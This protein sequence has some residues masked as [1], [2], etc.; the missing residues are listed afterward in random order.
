MS[1]VADFAYRLFPEKKKEYRPLTP[2]TYPANRHKLHDVKAVIIDVYG[3]LINYWREEF[4]KKEAKEHCLEEAFAKTAQYFQFSEILRQ[5]NP[6]DEP[7]RTLRDF[8]HGLIALNHEKS[9][10]KGIEFPEVRIEEVWEVVIMMLARHGYDPATLNLGDN[11]ELARCI[12]WYYN[13]FSLGCNLYEGVVSG[14]SALKKKN[15]K[16]GILADAQFY[17]PI[18]LT[19]LVREQSG[20][21]L[22]D[23]L[24][25]FNVDL[26]FYSYEQGYTKANQGLYRKLF[27]ALYEHQILPSQTVFVGNDLLLDIRPA[28]Q[29]GMRTALFTGDDKSAFLHDVGG[30][31]IPDITFDS[32]EELPEKLLFNEENKRK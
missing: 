14:L 9:V 13:F 8:Y 26:L 11:K 4:S 25:L 28:D 17:T 16:I 15:I 24:E 18:D 19:L 10:R 5:M 3:T 2:L 22:D 31:V 21:A 7:Q 12:A 1:R 20:D 32:W 30:E 6:A 29:I 27:D 23:Y